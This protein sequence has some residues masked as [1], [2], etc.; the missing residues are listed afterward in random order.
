M[1]YIPSELPPPNS[2]VVVGMSGGVDSTLTALLLKEK[3]CHVIGVTMSIW[4]GHIPEIPAVK[5][6]KKFHDA[7]Y[8]PEEKEDIEE[9]FKFCT[10]HN[11]EYHV[12]D[13]SKEYNEIVLEYFKEEYRKG[14]TPN[15]CIRCNSFIKFGALLE[16]IKKI[17]IDFDYL[18]LFFLFLQA[19]HQIL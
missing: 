18:C 8:G 17:N 11:I 10:E 1:K 16:G 15:P 14:K 6:E 7:C 9:C 4:D 5:N 12:I 3:G 2:T 19:M 13:V